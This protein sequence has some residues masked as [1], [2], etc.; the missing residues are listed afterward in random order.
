MNKTLS[1]VLAVV[2]GFA[3][4]AGIY[5]YNFSRPTG[6]NSV[7]IVSSRSGGPGI[8]GKDANAVRNAASVI[9]EYV[10][11]IDTVGTPIF[12]RIPFGDIFGS[13]G[14][15]EMVP[16]GQASGIVFSE[17]G[18]VLTNNHVVENTS[19]LKVTLNDGSSYDATLVGR[20][21]QTDLA[22]I[23]INPKGKIKFAE[24]GDSDAIQPGDWVIAVGNALGLGTT[25]TVGVVSAKREE[26]EINGKVFSALIQTDAA[27]NH[28][29]SGGA[30]ADLNGK[31][32]GINTAIMSTSENGGSIGV[33]FAVP[34]K[35]IK[36]IA[37]QIIKNGKV[38]RPYLGIRYVGITD[39]VRKNLESKGI[40]GLPKTGAIII[41]V[42]DGSPAIVAG[43][44][45]GDV[46]QKIND[47]EITGEDKSTKKAKTVSDAVSTLKPG[48]TAKIELW[49]MESG[50]KGVVSVKIGDM[51]TDMREREQ[52]QVAPFMGR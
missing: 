34:T 46:I 20:D 44:Q 5:N 36:N 43:I 21:P 4:C 3:A 28:G 16:R 45:P 12:E 50:K 24:F 6:D 13:M 48:D 41:E 30:L 14:G 7:K 29:N 39:G 52:R 2:L 35:T 26:F 37:D 49:H 22:V 9:S 42:Y 1:H 11:N 23:K 8:V 31:V 27:I 47:Q 19:K 10:V 33:G 40:A 15:R 25:V 32:I 38:S 17:N 51:P 18:Y